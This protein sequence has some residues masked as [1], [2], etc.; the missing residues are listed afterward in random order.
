MAKP[1]FQNCFILW[2]EEQYEEYDPL[3]DD[4]RELVGPEHIVVVRTENEGRSQ[5]R[6]HAFDLVLLDLM[7]P[8]N[9]DE[10]KAG[11][12]R[13]EA[14]TRLL[15]ELRQNEGWAT[16]RDC[17]VVVLTA[18]GNPEALKEV[19]DLLSSHGCL[20]QKPIPIEDIV[21]KVKNVLEELQRER[22]T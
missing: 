2:I 9:E 15:H 6:E 12:I 21:Q 18:R 17:N 11:L 22:K 5:L 13:L 3:L 4:L 19:E 8:R 20:I 1:E 14:G 16:H 7:L 10:R